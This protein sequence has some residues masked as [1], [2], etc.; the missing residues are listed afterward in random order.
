MEK[1]QYYLRAGIPSTYTIEEAYNYT[2]GIEEEP[3]T[4]TTPLHLIATHCPENLSDDEM[5]TVNEMVTL[6]LE[7]G[8]G[9]CLTDI[10]NETPG[11]ILIRRGFKKTPLY[12][13][14]VDA[15]VRAEVLLRKVSEYDVEFIDDEDEVPELVMGKEADEKQEE[16]KEGEEVAK[17][18]AIKEGI[19]EEKKDPAGNQEAYLRT[20]LEYKDDA[21]LTSEKDGVMMLWETDLMQK[22][23]DTLF[24]TAEKEV[25]ILNIGFGM[26]I[27]DTMIN[28]RNPTRHYICEAHPDVLMK[29]KQEGWYEKPNVVVL[30]GRWQDNLDA[31]LTG[32]TFFDGIYYDTFS[33]HYKDMLALF[34][35]VVGLLKPSGVFSFFNGLGADR[36]VIY[37][38]YRN[39]VE[40]D[41]SNYGLQCQMEE[42]P[43]KNGDVFADVKRSYWLCPVYYHPKAT[44]LDV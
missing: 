12:Q 10:N 43:V 6:L 28:E 42:I 15:G 4:T 7:H 27:I 8:A 11:C 13:Q 18:E 3:P 39:L 17:E 29:M 41:L 31:L 36:E 14:I 38:V 32:E 40:M 9:W 24:S 25:N 21:L 34:D 20:K 30:E 26:G 23:C 22:G 19:K 44:F 37:D 16:S 1:L 5:K 33:E 2:H 35:Y